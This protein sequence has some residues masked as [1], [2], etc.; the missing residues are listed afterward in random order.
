MRNFKKLLNFTVVLIIA[1]VTFCSISFAATVGAALPYKETGWTRISTYNNTNIKYLGQFTPYYNPGYGTGVRIANGGQ[2]SAIFNFYGTKLRIISFRNTGGYS[3]SVQVK[4]DGVEADKYSSMGDSIIYNLL[5]FE[6]TNLQ[7]GV[8]SVEITPLDSS[9]YGT[10]LCA[11]DIDETGYLVSTPAP[12]NLTAEANSGEVNLTWNAVEGATSYKV[13][14]G[15]ISGQYD[16]TIP[17]IPT[18]T[19]SS[20]MFTDDGIENGTT[21]YYV[22][23]ALING[24]D[25]PNSIEVSA[26]SMQTIPL[27]P[28][29]LTAEAGN[30]QVTLKWDLVENATGYNVKRAST[31]GGQYDTF[32]L[33][34]QSPPFVDTGVTNGNTY[35]YTVSVIVNGVESPDSNVEPATPKAPVIVGNN[36]ILEITML[37]GAIKEYDLTPGELQD[38]LTWYDSKSDGIGKAYYIFINKGIVKPFLNKTEYIPFDKILSFEVNEYAA[39]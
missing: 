19:G 34:V 20:I 38:F 29:N 4:I 12:T 17:Y 16:T 25:G 7:L 10:I 27:P 9:T 23:S 21:Y 15:T 24:L 11:L 36:A 18:T 32:S 6:E 28:T 3:S 31:S 8:H 33:N 22:V 30:G 2:G 35:Y 37:N 39:G 13:K 26:T 5:A 1:M 14:R